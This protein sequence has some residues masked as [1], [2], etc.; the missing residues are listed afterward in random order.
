MSTLGRAFEVGVTV[1]S[2][3]LVEYAEMRSDLVGNRLIGCGHE[4]GPPAVFA[5]CDHIIDDFGI[6]RQLAHIDSRMPDQRL[7]ILRATR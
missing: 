4:H 3:C 1:R 2:E 5:P 6:V 7:L